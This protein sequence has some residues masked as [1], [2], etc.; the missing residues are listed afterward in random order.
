M[1]PEIFHRAGGG[2]THIGR[3]TTAGP[4]YKNL[5]FTFCVLF[6]VFLLRIHHRGEVTP[7]IIMIVVMF[8][9]FLYRL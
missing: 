9:E 3:L 5:S 1:T 7:A 8:L 4:I 6:R 2:G